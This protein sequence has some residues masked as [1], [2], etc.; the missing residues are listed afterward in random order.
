MLVLLV[1]DESAL[2]GLAARGLRASGYEVVEASTG[3]D[4]LSVAESYP[5]RI[6]LLLTDLSM[7]DMDGSEL[8]K[9]LKAAHPDLKVLYMSGYTE[10]LPGDAAYIQKPFTM[11]ALAEKVRGVLG[12]G[13]R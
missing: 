11:R 9:R 13:N 12:T 6:D 5:R 1:D 4:A 7:P 8:A 2:R 10:S 3:K